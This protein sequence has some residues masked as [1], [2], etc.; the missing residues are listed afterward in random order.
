MPELPEV[1]TVAQGLRRRALGRRIVTVE[2]RHAAVIAW[3]GRR[4]LFP[5]SQAEGWPTSRARGRRLPSRLT[6]D[7][8]SPRAFC[9]CAWE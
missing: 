4:N 1:E 7:D 3:I 2:V 6:A 9:W 5:P 8:G